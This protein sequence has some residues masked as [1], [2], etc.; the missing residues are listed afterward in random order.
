MLGDADSGRMTG[1]C[2]ES[3]VVRGNRQGCAVLASCQ[4]SPQGGHFDAK[5]GEHCTQPRGVHLSRSRLEIL[6]QHSWRSSDST[7]VGVAVSIPSQRICSMPQ[8]ARWFTPKSRYATTTAAIITRLR[9]AQSGQPLT[10]ISSAGSLNSYPQGR[11]GH[12]RPRHIQRP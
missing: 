6:R 3:H 12:H 10:I 1:C 11:R 4:L 9:P 7:A 8:R 5:V 2:M